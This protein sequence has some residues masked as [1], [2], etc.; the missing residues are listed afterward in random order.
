MVVDTRQPIDIITTVCL[1]CDKRVDYLQRTLWAMRKY[2]SVSRP[3]R[4]TISLEWDPTN[5]HRLARVQKIVK[6]HEATLIMRPENSKARL[7]AHLDFCL[8]QLKSDLWFYLQDDWELVRPINLDQGIE[9]IETHPQIGMVRYWA[10]T[11]WWN[12]HGEKWGWAD[13]GAPYCI[14]YNPAIWHR[15]LFE[16]LKYLDCPRYRRASERDMASRFKHTPFQAIA[17]SEVVTAASYYFRHIGHET[18]FA[19]RRTEG[20][21]SVTQQSRRDARLRLVGGRRKR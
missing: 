10:A 11:R 2:L 13:R 4:Y 15:R 20:S 3:V 21:S 5:S 14:A 1:T 18:A 8:P 19:T 6:D 12:Y 17:P 7:G 9:M 16:S